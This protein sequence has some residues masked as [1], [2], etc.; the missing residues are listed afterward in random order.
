MPTAASTDAQWAAWWAYQTALTNGRYDDER[1]AR[2]IVTDRQH[3]EK[4]AAEAACA[5]AQGRLADAQMAMVTALAAPSPVRLP[6][7]A[8]MVFE[9]LK[10]HPQATILTNGQLVNGCKGIVD[11][12]VAAH[13]SAVQ[14]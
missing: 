13:P 6:T 10:V 2:Q 5:A 9:L 12:Y 4:M 11:A 8:E 7:R 1:A 3:T 14:P